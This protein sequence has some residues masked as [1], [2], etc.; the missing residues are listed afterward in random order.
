MSAVE[1]LRRRSGLTQ[2]ELAAVA[3]TSQPTIAAYE[4]GRKSPT[5]RTLSRVARS[6]GFEVV[7]QFVEPM[8]REERRSLHLHEAIGA[9][10]IADP[11]DVLHRARVNLRRMADANPD[12]ESLLSEWRRIL[13]RP[14]VEI[15]DLLVDPRRH[16]RELR[17]VTPFAGA[18]SQAERARV[19]ERFRAL[20]GVA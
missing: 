15:V 17:H 8:T 12:A 20:E 7:V 9:R 2:A 14:V 4:S 11:A 1:S 13:R 3:G 19:Y 18:L 5:L 16:A 10:L 6:V